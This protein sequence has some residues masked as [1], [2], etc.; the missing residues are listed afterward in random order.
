MSS[1]DFNNAVKAYNDIH[2][3]ISKL[4]KKAGELRKEKKVVGDIILGYMKQNNIDE[5]ELRN[6]KLVRKVSK[7]TE[8]L[9]KEYI[10]H[11]LVRL[12]G[13]DQAAAAALNSMESHRQIKETEILSRLKINAPAAEAS[14][15]ED[16]D[17]ESG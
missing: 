5:C 17:D 8:T 6:C 14:E 11:E 2:V 13:S 10:L 16:G 7:R 1:S 9:K 15:E 12:T 3:Q 4:T